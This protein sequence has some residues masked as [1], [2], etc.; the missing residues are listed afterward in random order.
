MMQAVEMGS[1]TVI[2]IPGFIKIGSDI[3]KLTG[4]GTQTDREHGDRTSILHLS[5]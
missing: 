1:C 4:R 3:R 5:K 2:C